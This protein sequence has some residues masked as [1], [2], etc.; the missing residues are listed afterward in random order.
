[1]ITLALLFAVVLV[2]EIIAFVIFEL[3]MPGIL[4]YLCIKKIREQNEESK[5]KGDK[6]K[7]EQD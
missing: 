7:G 4:V 1:M 5:E 6:G 3:C 2:I